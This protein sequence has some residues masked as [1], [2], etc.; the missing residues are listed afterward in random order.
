MPSI[1]SSGNLVRRLSGLL[2]IKSPS[3]APIRDPSVAFARWKW[4]R[5]FKAC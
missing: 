1:T 5:K 4:A 2:R 3:K